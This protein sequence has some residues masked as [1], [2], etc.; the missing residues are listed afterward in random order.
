MSRRRAWG[1]KNVCWPVDASPGVSGIS[2]ETKEQQLQ[3]KKRVRL[4]EED[5]EA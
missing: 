2:R 5:P 1:M 3:K 4:E